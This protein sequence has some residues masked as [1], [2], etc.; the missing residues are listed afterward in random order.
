MKTVV[1]TFVIEEVEAL[2]YDNEKLDKWND[3]VEKLGLKGQLAIQKPEKSPI[4]F[5]YMN[6][7]LI[8]TFQCLCPRSVDIKEFSVTPIPVEILELVSLS[9]NE[10]YFQR[11]IGCWDE[12]NPDPVVIGITGHWYEISWYETSN[13]SLS[14]QKFESKESAEMAGAKHPSFS[15]TAKYLIGKWGD[16]KYSFEQ[17]KEMATKRFIAERTNEIKRQMKD[18]QRNLDDIQGD[19]FNRFGATVSPTDGFI[20]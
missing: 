17:L 5:L 13:K 4:P 12:K 8:E 10:K 16:V 11:I 19:A 18:L 15:E 3:H 1:E 9:V 2:I 7:G 20:F 14:G 6:A